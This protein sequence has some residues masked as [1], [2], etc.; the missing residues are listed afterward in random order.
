MYRVVGRLPPDCENWRGLLIKSNTYCPTKQKEPKQ[1]LKGDDDPKGKRVLRA[2][3]PGKTA[4]HGTTLDSINCKAPQNWCGDNPLDR[5]HGPTLQAVS[6]DND[7]HQVENQ[8][9]DSEVTPTLA[10][11]CRKTPIRSQTA[12]RVRTCLSFWR[13]S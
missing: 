4:H 5:G 1:K 10:S 12:E 13:R 3:Y 11:H 2:I 9:R 8:I 6:F 7:G